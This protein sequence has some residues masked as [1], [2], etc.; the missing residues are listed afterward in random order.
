V[1]AQRLNTKLLFDREKKQ[2]TNNPLANML[3]VG[4]AP[5]KGWEAYY[6]L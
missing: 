5:R 6:T 3:L 4:E 2:I 1:I